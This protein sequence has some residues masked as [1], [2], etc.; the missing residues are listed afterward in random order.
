[1]TDFA[2][3]AATHLFVASMAWAHGY[4]VA[5]FFQRRRRL[6]AAAWAT[7]AETAFVDLTEPARPYDWAVDGG[8]ECPDCH[9]AGETIVHDPFQRGAY[10]HAACP[11]CSQVAP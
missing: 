3:L 1:M 10:L 2:T 5:A 9:G 11:T 6:E 4:V 7:L 8:G